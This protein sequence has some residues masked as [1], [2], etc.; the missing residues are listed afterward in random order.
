MNIEQKIIAARPVDTAP[1]GQFVNAVRAKIISNAHN[2]HTK[3]LT[4]LFLHRPLAVLLAI[5]AVIALVSGTVYAVGYLW[6]RLHPSVSTPQQSASGRAAVIVADCDKADAKK[7]YELKSGAPVSNDKISDV[8]K[9][10]CE[11]N[12]VSDWS[13][14]AY[15]NNRPERQ[16]HDI[17]TPGAVRENVTIWPAM[18]VDQ[19]VQINKDSL[20]V[21]DGGSLATHDLKP[22]PETRYIVDGQ[23]AKQSQLTAGDAIAYVIQGT[24][25]LKNQADCTEAHCQ[26]DILSSSD[27]LLAVVKMKYSFDVYR[28][29]R[30]LTELPVCAGNPNDECPA[31]S[32]IDLYERTTGEPGTDWAEISGK[33][34][35]YNDQSITITTTSGRQVV[36]YTPWNLISSYN[37][38]RSAGYGY[39]INAGDTLSVAYNQTTGITSDTEIPWKRLVGVRLLVEASSKAGPYNK[40]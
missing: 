23:Y 16:D 19:L 5:I 29:I 13:S 27:K 17:N 7:R 11:L 14:A 6:P 36:V 18:F 28:S 2:K 25:T 12:T 20:T 22:T 30:Y 34:V 31:L 4:V 9:A 39:T 3:K 32:S 1:S 24:V 35:T 38:D 37:A 8:V 40:Y 21:A 10:Q 33:I 15:P 26:A